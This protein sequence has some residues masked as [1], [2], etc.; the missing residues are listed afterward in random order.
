[1]KKADDVVDVA[2]TTARDRRTAALA[3]CIRY[4]LGMRLDAADL[5]SNGD[6][7]R[8]DPRRIDSDTMTPHILLCIADRNRT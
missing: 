8:Y 5:L 6:A 3:W 7:E 4:V 2:H 1:M